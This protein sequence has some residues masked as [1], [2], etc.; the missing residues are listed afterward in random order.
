MQNQVSHDHVCC[1]RLTDD[2]SPA[3]RLKRSWSYPVTV[4][5]LQN[6]DFMITPTEASFHNFQVK[7]QKIHQVITSRMDTDIKEAATTTNLVTQGGT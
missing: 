7:R 2:S 1:H 6:V 4:I 3:T 5:K